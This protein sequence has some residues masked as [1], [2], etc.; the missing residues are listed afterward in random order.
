[1]FVSQTRHAVAALS[2]EG[3][4][5]GEI[6]QALGLARNTVRYHLQ[7]LRHDG[8]AVA[9]LTPVEA[10]PPAS[11]PVA[12]RDAVRE[13]LAQGVLRAEI[14]LRLDISPATVTYH[15]RRLG[16]AVD[17]RCARRY[18]WAKVQAHYDTGHSARDCARAF[19]FSLQSWHAARLRGDITT[20]GAA[21]PLSE[22]LVVGRYRSRQNIKRRLLAEGIKQPACESCGADA[23]LGRPIPLDLHHVNGIRDDNRL[24][25]LMLVCPNCHAAI[26]GEAARSAGPG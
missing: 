20:R 18:D 16:A 23:W 4:N 15:A 11:T 25:N 26:E 12:T 10:P 24:E 6:A 5:V 17:E 21:M 3:R 19:G 14:A 22:L 9:A 1:M 13:L 2:A 8:V 7:R